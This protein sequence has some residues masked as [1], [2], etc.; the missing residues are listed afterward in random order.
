M[1][2]ITF[3]RRGGL[4]LVC[5]KISVEGSGVTS[6]TREEGDDLGYLKMETVVRVS[7]TSPKVFEVENVFL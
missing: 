1:L 7:E 4:E 3:K 5:V 2:I 6:I